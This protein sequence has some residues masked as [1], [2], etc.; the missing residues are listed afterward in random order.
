MIELP[1]PAAFNV[2]VPVA[3]LVKFTVAALLV[4]DPSVAVT[5]KDPLS[6]ALSV[7]V[8]VP[9]V[10]T[11]AAPNPVPVAEVSVPPVTVSALTPSASP[12]GSVK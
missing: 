11:L 2:V 9:T 8:M 4:A 7:I 6:V 12:S 5:V 3:L 1:V 10:P